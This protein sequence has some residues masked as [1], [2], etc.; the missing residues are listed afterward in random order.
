MDAPEEY[1][2]TL[3]EKGQV[4]VPAAVRRRLGIK[5]R[6]KVVFRIVGERVELAPSPL[7]LANTFGA[8]K[9]RKQPEDFK[10]L[11]DLALDEHAQQVIQDMQSQ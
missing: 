7:S 10:E 9:P 1:V 5:P 3:T 6:D 8:V 11:R 2:G 4:T